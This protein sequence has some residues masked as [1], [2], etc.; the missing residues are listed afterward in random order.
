MM[1]W[2]RNS[3]MRLCG[4]ECLPASEAKSEALGTVPTLGF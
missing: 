2:G 3:E 4:P 1:L